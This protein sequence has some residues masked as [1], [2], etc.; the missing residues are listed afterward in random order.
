LRILRK[1]KVYPLQTYSQY[2]QQSLP[3][4]RMSEA[5][6]SHT[7]LSHSR[8]PSHSQHNLHRSGSMSSGTQSNPYGQGISYQ[9]F[10][11]IPGAQQDRR[12]KA[13]ANSGSSGSH[14]G[15]RPKSPSSPP[16]RA[17]PV[18]QHS[19]SQPHYSHPYSRAAND[20]ADEDD[21]GNR[22]S[23]GSLW[24]YAVY[25]HGMIDEN[26][27]PGGYGASGSGSGSG[28]ARTRSS[29]SPAP[30][31]R[32]V[33]PYQDIMPSMS[34]PN[35][36]STYT[37]SS[38]PQGHVRS[39]SSQAS[40][41]MPMS[42]P[43]QSG[44]TPPSLYTCTTIHEFIPPSNIPL[45]KTLAKPFLTLTRGSVVHVLRE[46]GTPSKI[47]GFCDIVEDNGEDCLLMARD[48]RGTVGWCLA[49]FLLPL[50]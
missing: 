8:S 49:S 28:G 13:S 1:E 41:F 36:A 12:S 11:S 25:H 17:P 20:D 42:P 19:Y 40:Q 44:N 2:S 9:S 27:M 26:P 30:G 50:T 39:P 38:N 34:P 35:S 45:S 15:P 3:G 7:S 31:G 5:T 22:T 37:R 10:S 43:P 4:R 46:L 29:T 33:S 23:A 21:G 24:D 18:L 14:S 47:P 6:S 32:P 16:P 48:E